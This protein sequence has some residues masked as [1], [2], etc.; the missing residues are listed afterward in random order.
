MVLLHVFFFVVQGFQYSSHV[1]FPANTSAFSLVPIAS[2]II[3]NNDI[4]LESDKEYQLIFK[5]VSKPA[6]FVIL[7][8]PTTITVVDDDS[9]LQLFFSSVGH[10]FFALVYMSVCYHRTQI[11]I[12]FC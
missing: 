4:G 6:E 11:I 12:S 7:G 5:N 3:D 8:Q 10:K 9:K 2:F 1:L